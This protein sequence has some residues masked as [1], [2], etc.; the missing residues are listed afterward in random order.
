MVMAR[1]STSEVAGTSEVSGSGPRPVTA[2]ILSARGLS[3]RFG[4]L[5]VLHDVDLDLAPGELVALV[6]E[7][8]AGK[9]TLIRCLV[10]ALVPEAGEVTFE[11]RP[12]GEVPDAAHAAGIAVVW[13]NLA[14]CDNLD[15][16]ANLFLGQEWG[17]PLLSDAEMYAE[18][19]TVLSDLAI[20]VP[21]LNRPVGLLSGGQRQM[22]AVARAFVTRPRVLL[23]DEPTAAL[24]VTETRHVNELLGRLRQAGIAMLLVSHRMDQVFELADRIVVLRRGRWWPTCHRSR[25]TPTT[26][27]TSWRASRPIRR[28]ASSCTAC[29]ASST[30]SPRWSRRP[31]CR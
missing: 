13:Q 8:G 24:G 31:R 15:V 16:V 25:S 10:G 21:D 23:L 22:I 18:A 1:G 29:T 7:N 5:T 17:A 9:S 30:S 26:W 3:C 14:L 2:P 19:R 20:D 12:H 6:G 4:D 28:P 27:S 11:G